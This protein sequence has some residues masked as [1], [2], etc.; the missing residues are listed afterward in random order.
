M[1]LAISF[2]TACGDCVAYD[3][4]QLVQLAAA[5]EQLHEALVVLLIGGRSVTLPLARQALRFL[6]ELR[7]EELGAPAGANR[8][9]SHGA[10]AP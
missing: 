10:A 8:P 1:G 9:N 2:A 3:L 4:Q 5:G 7:G 6:E